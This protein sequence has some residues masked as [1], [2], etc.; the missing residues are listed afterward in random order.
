MLNNIDRGLAVEVCCSET[1]VIDNSVVGEEGT[2]GLSK[3]NGAISTCYEPSRDKLR[4]LIFKS[5][6]HQVRLWFFKSKCN[7]GDQ[8]SNQRDIQ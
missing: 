6:R 3:S 2:P 8:I 5:A 7:G 1:E 4:F